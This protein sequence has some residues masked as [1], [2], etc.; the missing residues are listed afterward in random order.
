RQCACLLLA[1]K[2]TSLIHLLMSAND[3]KRTCA[4]AALTR[5]QS[6][7][8][9][10]AYGTACSAPCPCRRGLGR[11]HVLCLYGVAA[12][13]GAARAGGAAFALASGLRPL[14]PMGVGEHC[15]S[16]GK[17][18]RNAVP[19]FRWVHGRRGACPPHAGHGHCD[20]TAVPALVLRAL[21]PF[22]PGRRKGDILRSR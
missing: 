15:P 2:R 22:W 21:A 13:R 20:D 8:I 14:F 5:A 16:G 3:P 17:R 19:I 11:R 18:L 9:I 1:I 6:H 12:F 7:M 4:D 10:S